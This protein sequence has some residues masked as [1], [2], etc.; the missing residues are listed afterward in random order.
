MGVYLPRVFDN[1]DNDNN[2]NQNDDYYN[3]NHDVKDDIIII[4]IEKS[5]SISK[6]WCL[7]SYVLL[8]SYNV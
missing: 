1:D 2:N 6:W 4:T 5:V 7:P 8:S 3:D